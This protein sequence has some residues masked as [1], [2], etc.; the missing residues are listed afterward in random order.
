MPVYAGPYVKELLRKEDGGRRIDCCRVRSN[1]CRQSRIIVEARTTRHDAD[2][3][4]AGMLADRPDDC[5]QI[6]GAL[7]VADCQTYDGK[8]FALQALSR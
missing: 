6:I 8:P 7:F 3:W 4:I 2:G 5:G 1:R